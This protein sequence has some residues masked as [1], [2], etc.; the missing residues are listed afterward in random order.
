M[1]ELKE[2]KKAPV[3]RPVFMEFDNRPNAISNKLLL[4]SYEIFKSQLSVLG[5]ISTQD[6]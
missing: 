5:K 1:N 6:S 2:D 4:S 3:K